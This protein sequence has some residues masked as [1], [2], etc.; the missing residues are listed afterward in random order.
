MTNQVAEIVTFKLAPGIS[1]ADFTALSQQS[2]AFVR[3]CPGF[4]NR[5]LSQSADGSWT[6]YV[7]WQDIE[8]A[9][10]AAAQF[11][12]QDFAPALM[13]AIAPDSVVMRHEIIHWQMAAA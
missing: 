11:P 7:V 13:Q 4:R 8:A 5:R 9:Q 6:D 1:E 3:A 2:E 10:A 12:Q